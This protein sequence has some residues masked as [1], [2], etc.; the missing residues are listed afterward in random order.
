[1][2]G[3]VA[4]ALAVPQ[5]V[6]LVDEHEA[7]AAQLGQLG[8]NLAQRENAPA[9]PVPLAVILPHRCQVL[10]AD[11]Q[12]LQIVV[13]L[14]DAGDCGGHQGLSEPHHIADEDSA[15]FVQVACGD[16]DR[17]LLEAEELVFEIAG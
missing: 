17:R 8:D 15:A 13:V 4:L 10:G 16:L 12:R 6:A 14:E 2:N 3:V 7:V 11:N 9:Q 5:V 1:M